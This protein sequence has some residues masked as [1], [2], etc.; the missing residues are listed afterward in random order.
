MATAAAE[1]PIDFR[2]FFKII[3]VYW[4]YVPINPYSQ[5]VKPSTGRDLTLVKILF[6]IVLASKFLMVSSEIWFILELLMDKE[7]PLDVTVA[8][9]AISWLMMALMAFEATTMMYRNSVPITR[10]LHRMN[11]LFP[12]GDQTVAKA[13]LKFWNVIPNTYIRVSFV[14]TMVIIFGPLIA[15]IIYYLFTGRWEFQLPMYLR[16]PFDPYAP[17]IVVFVYAWEAWVVCASTMILSAIAL[18]V[19]AMV[20]QMCLQYKM[21]AND[22]QALKFRPNNYAEDRAKLVVLM[23]KHSQLIEVG[24]ELHDS[25]ALTLVVNY[26]LSSMVIC[27]FCFLIAATDDTSTFV[28]VSIDLCCFL[29]YNSIFSFFGQQL[30][31]SVS[32][33]ASAHCIVSQKYN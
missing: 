14:T 21:L 3:K 17:A 29:C 30:I 6:W 1:A 5:F 32:G 13:Q 15:S 20:M 27:L 22:L 12:R 2:D 26:L 11:D 23:Q 19:G 28:I 31:D 4:S 16:Y 24:Q 25:Y 10:L 18:L 9:S 8:A 33:N 7:T